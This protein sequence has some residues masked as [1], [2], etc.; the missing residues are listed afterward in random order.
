MGVIVICVVVVFFGVSLPMSLHIVIDG[1][2]APSNRRRRIPTG[3]V[4]WW[5]W[6][7]G[8]WEG[9]MAGI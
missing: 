7:V 4:E 5:S 2:A 6:G 1:A 9:H 3:W 8:K